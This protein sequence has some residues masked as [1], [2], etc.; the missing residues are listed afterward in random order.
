MRTLFIRDRRAGKTTECYRRL[1]ANPKAMMLVGNQ[2]IAMSAPLDIKDRV[3][4][5]YSRTW[6]GRDLTEIIVDDIDMMEPD[7]IIRLLDHVSFIT[8]SKENLGRTLA[9]LFVC[10]PD[11]K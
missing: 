6:I 11:E 4:S 7:K 1:R 10:Q 9:K 8:I 3:F 5:H 2:E